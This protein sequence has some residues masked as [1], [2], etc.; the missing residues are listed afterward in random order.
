MSDRLVTDEELDRALDYLVNSA[1]QI[2]EARRKQILT[3]H[4]VK[5]TK[6]LE[7]KKHNDMPVSAQEREAVAS[8][9]YKNACYEEAVTAGEFEKLR[10]LREAASLKIEVWR[11]EQSSLR[12]LGKLE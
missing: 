9:C 2:G 10:A 1:A 7:M 12:S 3:T 11:T 4:M 6:A 8:D 5:H